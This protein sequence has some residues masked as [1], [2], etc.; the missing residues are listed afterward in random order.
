ME[1]VGWKDALPFEELVVIWQVTG[2]KGTDMTK[3]RGMDD[4]LGPRP[5]EV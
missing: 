5:I 1:L 4:G 2:K 3:R